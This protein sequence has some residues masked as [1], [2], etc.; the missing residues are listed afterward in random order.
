MYDYVHLSV[1][2]L[3][4]DEADKSN[5]SL[6]KEINDNIKNGSLISTEIICKLLEN[7]CL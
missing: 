6:G 3:L 2:D 4:R 7:V 1:G 5:S